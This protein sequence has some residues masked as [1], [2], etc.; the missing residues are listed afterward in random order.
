MNFSSNNY[1][2]LSIF[3]I[4]KNSSVMESRFLGFGESSLS[5]WAT[6][7]VD[8]RIGDDGTYTKSIFTLEFLCTKR[9]QG[10]SLVNKRTLTTDNITSSR[11]SQYKIP[12]G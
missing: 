3:E 4:Q 6:D 9:F 5:P 1:L 11:N 12:H 2:S 10:G 8:L 7:N